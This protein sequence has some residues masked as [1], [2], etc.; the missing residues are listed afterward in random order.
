MEFFEFSVRM[1]D[2]LGVIKQEV[3]NDI[4]L[5]HLAVLFD[6]AAN[7]DT[8]IGEVGKR[9]GMPS[10]SISR[11]VAALS[12]WSWTKKE[13][14]GLLQKEEDLFESRRKVLRLTQEGVKLIKVMN[15]QFLKKSSKLD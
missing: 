4:P 13:G 11:A 2:A 14:Y 6:V 9:L 8:S 15:Q 10:S 1:R 3:G 12:R 7:P 5:Q